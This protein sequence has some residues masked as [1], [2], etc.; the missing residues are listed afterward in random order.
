MRVAIPLEDRRVAGILDNA[1]MLLVVDLGQGG[2]SEY[3]QTPVRTRSRQG[4]ANELASM[5]VDTV[6]CDGVSRIL[7]SMI[8]TRGIAVISHVTGNVDEVLEG[9]HRQRCGSPGSSLGGSAIQAAAS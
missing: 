4:R 9:F 7:E 3:F 6:V 8:L 5:G 2:R 1:T